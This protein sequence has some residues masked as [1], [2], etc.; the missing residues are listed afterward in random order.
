MELLLELLRF[1]LLPVQIL[2]QNL[3]GYVLFPSVALS[4]SN[5]RE[6]TFHSIVKVP[7]LSFR[8]R[9]SLYLYTKGCQTK[10]KPLTKASGLELWVCH[11]V[12]EALQR[13]KRERLS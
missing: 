2:V 6:L 4:A 10:K 3:F 8:V 12:I 1:A 7:T 5:R 9:E 13:E 11:H